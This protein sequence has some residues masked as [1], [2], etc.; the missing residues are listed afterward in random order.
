M[1][2]QKTEFVRAEGTV[3]QQGTLV[4]SRLVD[5]FDVAAKLV[6]QGES[7]WAVRTLVRQRFIVILG[8]V[9]AKLVLP[10]KDAAAGSA[11]GAAADS[12]QLVSWQAVL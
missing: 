6:E 10:A 7:G 8:S 4:V 2:P 5:A 11:G 3:G 9:Q 12:A 1:L